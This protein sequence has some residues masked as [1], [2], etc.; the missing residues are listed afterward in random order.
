[1]EIPKPPRYNKKEDLKNSHLAVLLDDYQCQWHRFTKDEIRQGSFP[2][3]I[4]GR[5][6]RW[7]LDS[8]ITLCYECHSDVHTA[9]QKDS[10]TVITKDFLITLME[11][12]VI[13]ARRVKHGI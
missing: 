1:M 10:K 4:W 11:K 13:P 12:K 5:R 6:R 8:Q 9:K 2:H 7:D 3:H